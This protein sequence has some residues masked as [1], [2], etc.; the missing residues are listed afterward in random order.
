MDTQA[1]KESVDLLQLVGG[2]LKRA[3]STRGGEYAGPCPKCGGKDRLHV[4]PETGLWMCRQCHPA[5]GDAIELLQWRDGLGFIEACAAL[6][7]EA[8]PATR[9]ASLPRAEPAPVAAKPPA[10]EWQATGMA[11]VAW[12]QERLWA[13]NGPMDYL[14]ERGLLEPTVR[15]ARLGYNPKPM[16]MDGKRWGLDGTVFLPRGWVIPWHEGGHLWAVKI[17]R[18]PD[19]LHT[20]AARERK[21]THVR[22]GSPGGT[23]YGGETFGIHPDAILTEGEFDALLLRQ[24][25]GTF[26]HVGTLGACNAKPNGDAIMAMLTARRLWATYDNDRAGR[27]GVDGLQEACGRIKR[28]DLPDGM[29]KDVTDAHLAGLD[30]A[31]W[32][33]AGIGPESADQRLAW[34]QHYLVKTDE[35]SRLLYARDGDPELTAW[36]ALWAEWRRLS[37]LGSAT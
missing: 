22:G 11:F 37:H 18:H 13:D 28:L 2:N 34:I 6:G 7:G 23:L 25:V 36:L 4:Q 35:S 10:R 5:W 14:A 1:L 31:E 15:Q 33:V 9:Q 17:R 29:G 27:A 32:A 19:D 24:Q 3:A 16:E 20:E 12:A 30:L 26:C 21:Y 8:G